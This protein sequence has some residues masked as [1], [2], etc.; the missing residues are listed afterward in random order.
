M[1]FIEN[2][3]RVIES[4]EQR[5]VSALLA[6]RKQS[7]LARN[8][9]RMSCKTIRSEYFTANRTNELSVS[10]VILETKKSK[11]PALRFLRRNYSR[12]HRTLVVSAHCAL[13]RSSFIGSG[14]NE[15]SRGVSIELPAA[16]DDS[17]FSRC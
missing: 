1:H 14:E 11:N 2:T 17:S 4:A 3:S 12:C 10:L 7:M 16:V 5:T 9:S 6:W 15:R 8:A 13:S